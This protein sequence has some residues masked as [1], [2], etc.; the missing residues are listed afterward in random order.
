MYVCHT[1]FKSH[2]Y[3]YKVSG[4]FFPMFARAHIE[5][6]VFWIPDSAT[7]LKN[8]LAGSGKRVYIN[9]SLEHAE[10]ASEED[11]QACDGSHPIPGFD[12]ED[13]RIPSF[14]PEGPGHWR[15]VPM[16]IVFLVNQDD[17]TLG[18]RICLAHPKVKGFLSTLYL[19]CLSGPAK[20]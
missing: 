1:N 7:H 5:L 16:T 3:T 10:V 14:Q 20:S 12:V 17:L 13:W 2:I 15:R 8:V 19:H 11:Q 9:N 4:P 18:N 6:P